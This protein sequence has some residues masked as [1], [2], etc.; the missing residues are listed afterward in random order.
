MSRARGSLSWPTD[1][2]SRWASF[3]VSLHG[4]SVLGGRKVPMGQG[5]VWLDRG[6]LAFS[7]ANRPLRLP[8]PTHGGLCPTFS[9]VVLGTNQH[10]DWSSSGTVS[11]SKG[12]WLEREH[13]KQPQDLVWKGQCKP[14]PVTVAPRPL[15]RR[16]SVGH[17]AFPQKQFYLEW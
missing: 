2:N 8:A 5:G 9:P 1:I 13:E 12:I 11:H 4:L 3:S 16:L 14:K 17:R 10:L 7:P 15:H 6:A